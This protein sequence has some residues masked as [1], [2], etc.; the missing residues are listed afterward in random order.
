MIIATGGLLTKTWVQL[1]VYDGDLFLVEIA[2]FGILL[3]TELPDHKI[4]TS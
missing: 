1:L 3:H 2:N 4:R